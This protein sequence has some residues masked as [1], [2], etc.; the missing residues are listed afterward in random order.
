M[1][2]AQPKRSCARGGD[3]QWLVLAGGRP[4]LRT[5]LSRSRR[6]PAT[7]SATGGEPDTAALLAAASQLGGA[8][9][10]LIAV[11]MPLSRTSITG[12]R[13]AD[14]ALSRV[15]G[16][17]ACGTHSPSAT[18]PGLIADRLA[19]DLAAFGYPLLTRTINPRG[20]IEVYPHPALVELAGAARRLPYK[21]SKTRSYWPGASRAERDA[22]L[23][24]TW[25]AIAEL[26][27]AEIA[28]TREALDRAAALPLKAREDLLDAIV[29]CTVAIHALQGRARPFGDDDAAIWVP[30]TASPAA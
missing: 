10:A 11:D 24:E 2:S 23:A 29:C 5:F 26:L 13:E 16:A 3:R 18:R 15:Y 21:A 27:E 20:L 1:D 25:R 30:V 8:P 4:F 22:R 14:N 7:C 28:G 17:K 6:R 19:R 12:R 9:P